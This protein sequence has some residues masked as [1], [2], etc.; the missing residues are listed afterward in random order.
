MT[1]VQWVLLE[2]VSI[3]LKCIQN[4]QDLFF[5]LVLEYYHFVRINLKLI[6]E[7]RSILLSSLF[8][9][10]VYDWRKCASLQVCLYE[11]VGKGLNDL[12]AFDVNAHLLEHTRGD[13]LNLCIGSLKFP[14]DLR[15]FDYQSI[16]V[17]KLLQYQKSI[18]NE[19]RISSN[20]SSGFRSQKKHKI[21]MLLSLSEVRTTSELI[22]LGLL[23]L[24]IFIGN[25]LI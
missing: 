17:V 9:I 3:L 18:E 22:I 24:F 14:E 21:R 25:L 7:H 11:N 8:S 12:V 16:L 4:G 19:L 20:S 10:H 15:K 23:E 6:T 2:L 13:Y 5:A 1:I